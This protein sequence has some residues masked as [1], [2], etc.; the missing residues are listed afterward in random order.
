MKRRIVIEVDDE[1]VDQKHRECGGVEE[2]TGLCF[3]A[4]VRALQSHVYGP[5]AWDLAQI[6]I[7]AYLEAL[8]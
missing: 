6:A 8:P 4:A 7:K 2:L 1:I 3:L 5:D